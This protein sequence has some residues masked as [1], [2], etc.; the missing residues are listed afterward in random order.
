[1]IRALLSTIVVVM[2]F[3]L[4]AHAAAGE[5]MKCEGAIVKVE[6]ENV[7]VKDVGGERLMKVE[8]GTKITSGGK[9]VSV[10]ELKVGRKVKC[11]CDNRDGQTVCTTME[12][13]RD[14]P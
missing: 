11:V 7:T 10:D 2:F 4:F 3:G 8:P 9:P 5:E 1:M 13:M 12:I 6:G 14:T